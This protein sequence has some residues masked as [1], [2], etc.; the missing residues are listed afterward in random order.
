MLLSGDVPNAAEEGWVST[1][2]TG[3]TSS[4]RWPTSRATLIASQSW[5]N[6]SATQQNQSTT[7]RS[8][9]WL[10]RGHLRAGL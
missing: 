10:G 2:R 4:L 9:R 8:A 6:A 7:G 1:K 5:V 3:I